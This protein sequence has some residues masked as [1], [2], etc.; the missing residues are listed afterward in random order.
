V[1]ET[2]EPADGASFKEI[3]VRPRKRH[4][5]PKTPDAH[6]GPVEKLPS[7]DVP[8]KAKTATRAAP[9]AIPAQTVP[10]PK[11]AGNQPPAASKIP[12]II[13]RNATKWSRL[14]QAMTSRRIN[15]NNAKPCVDVI[16]VNPVTV[17]DFRAV[18]RLLEERRVPFH[19][20]ALPEAK[21]L[22]AVLRTVPVEIRVDD[23]KSELVVSIKV[24]RMISNRS[25]LPLPLVPVEMPKNKGQMFE[26]RSVCQ[27]RI[28]VERPHK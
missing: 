25:K 5:S 24:T 14:A 18:T 26:L 11:A 2:V 10:T 7:E 4:T 16:W 12:P 6:S 9:Q 28:S 27:L 8:K 3:K 22:R 23:V 17:D 20:F 13:V 21:T 15:F 19:S 1:E